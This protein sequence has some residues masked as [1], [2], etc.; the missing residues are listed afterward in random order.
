MFTE[1]QTKQRAREASAR[2]KSANKE[3]INASRR[4]TYAAKKDD[5]E[6]KEGRKL[7]NKRS[8][9]GNRETRLQDMQNYRDAGLRPKADP[10][11]SRAYHLKKKY[12]LTEDQFQERFNLQGRACAICNKE[13]VCGEKAFHTDHD[14]VT[15]AIR[16]ILCQACNKALGLAQ[17]NPKILMSMAAYLIQNEDALLG[18]QS[19][20]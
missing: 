4:A 6:F 15:G 20:F 5:P 10:A 18:G 3:A 2:Y 8:Y 19:H 1:E 13:H 7:K 16:G 11:K 9:L 14:H 17:D 12:G